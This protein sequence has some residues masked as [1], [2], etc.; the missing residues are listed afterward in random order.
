MATTALPIRMAGRVT[1]SAT[2]SRWATLSIETDGGHFVGRLFVP[3]TKKRASDVL[4]DDRPFIFLTE[5]SVDQSE[6]IEPFLAISKRY[7][8]TVRILHDGEP[9][10][11]PQS[12]G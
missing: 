9:E 3:E 8:K 1:A 10:T 11:L 4:C 7:I 2:R 5:V 12:R 6:T